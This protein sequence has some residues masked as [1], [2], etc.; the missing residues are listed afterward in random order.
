MRVP[1]LNVY[2]GQGVFDLASAKPYVNINL[3]KIDVFKT[4]TIG[5]YRV[6][7]F[8]ANHFY[9]D[10]ARFYLIEGEKT[11]LYA[12]D[13]GFFYDEVFEY[14]EKNNVKL[15]LISMD[16]TNIDI[17]IEDIHPH[18]GIP[19]INRLVEKLTSMGVIDKNTKKVINHF[20]HN[21]RPIHHEL[22]ERVKNYGYIVSYDGLT[23]EI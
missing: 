13:T 12:H 7:S 6:T 19:N 20:S 16:C 17:P 3:N 21:A 8:P 11:V 22:E 15:D 4:E 5:K 18:M 23:I 1:T 9:G 14:L 10:D 2:C